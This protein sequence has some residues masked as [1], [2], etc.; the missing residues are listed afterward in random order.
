MLAKDV[1]NSHKNII[2][3]IAKETKGYVTGPVPQEKVMDRKGNIDILFTGS[4]SPAPDIFEKL[5]QITYELRGVHTHCRIIPQEKDIR[6][7]C[8]EMQ[9]D[10]VLKLKNCLNPIRE[11]VS[12]DIANFGRE[13][14]TQH[15]TPEGSSAITPLLDIVEYFY[16]Y[17]NEHC[18]S[19]NIKKS[20]IIVN[21]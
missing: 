2:H 12:T 16:I 5:N 9:K 1:Y 4:N 3:R 10:D 18:R 8:S 7:I 6:I 15:K 20:E 13:I 14:L 19:V 17:K 21:Y 11:H